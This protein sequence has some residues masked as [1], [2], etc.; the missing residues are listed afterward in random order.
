MSD[1]VSIVRS[2]S[3]ASQKNALPV[4][5]AVLVLSNSSDQKKILFL[6]DDGGRVVSL[7]IGQR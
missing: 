7:V 1:D 3:G 5:R 6:S 4:G 2:G